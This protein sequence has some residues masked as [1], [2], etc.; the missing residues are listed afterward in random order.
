MNTKNNTM[1]QNITKIISIL[2]FPFSIVV[3]HSDIW[4]LT[5]DIWQVFRLKQ[6]V[7]ELSAG[8]PR[9]QMERNAALVGKMNHLRQQNDML[10]RQVKQKPNQNNGH[11][12]DSNRELSRELDMYKD[13][14]SSP[15]F[16]QLNFYSF[17]L[18]KN[19]QK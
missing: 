10:N 5:Y 2:S 6:V 18:L 19:F 8:S 13:R 12:E 3:W 4:N 1:P 17:Y 11:G 15:E 16:C 14:V 9:V 7:E